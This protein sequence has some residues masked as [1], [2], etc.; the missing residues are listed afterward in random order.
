[1]YCYGMVYCTVD[2]TV[3]LGTPTIAC[4]IDSIVYKCMYLFRA[5]T[6]HMSVRLAV[7]LIWQF[8]G[9]SSDCQIEIT[10]NTVVLS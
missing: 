1:M 3:I 2:N 4:K 10:A 8:A 9:F 6:Y 5:F 7:I